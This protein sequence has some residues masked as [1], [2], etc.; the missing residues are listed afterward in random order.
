MIVRLSS[1][2]VPLPKLNAFLDFVNSKEIPRYQRAAGFVRLF[3]SQRMC[4]SYAEVM[5][6]SLWSCEER[7]LKFAEEEPTV[8]TLKTAFDAIP[9][10]QR[11]YDF[12]TARDGHFL[13]MNQASE[14][15]D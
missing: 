15:V 4:V 6:F 9:M 12:L 7:I 8:Q 2:M 13:A 5:I 14:A 3:V 10:E 1:A 11:T